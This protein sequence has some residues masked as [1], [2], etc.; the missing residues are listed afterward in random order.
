M[1]LVDAL[2]V[3][4]WVVGGIFLAAGVA[5]LREPRR[6]RREA[7]ANY[8]LL[9]PSFERMLAVVLPPLEIGVGVGFVTG[10]WLSLVSVVAA[11]LL[12]GFSLA[13]AIN[14]LRGR[15]EIGCGCFG[16]QDRPISWWIVGRN[17]ALFAGS[18]L[19]GWTTPGPLLTAGGPGDS[20]KISSVAVDAVLA[21]VVIGAVLLGLALAQLRT[22]ATF[23]IVDHDHE[24]L[25][26]PHVHR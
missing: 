6:R 16:S 24:V 8:K 9:P 14:L 11:I 17:V 26:R 19:V 21:M 12:L 23:R 5:K 13:V 20:D 2:L 10:A 3:F 7:I 1:G 22:F 25:S 4:R 18:V 15:S